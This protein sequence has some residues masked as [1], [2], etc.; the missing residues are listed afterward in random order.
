MTGISGIVSQDYQE[1]LLEIVEGMATIQC[2][3]SGGI[4]VE[5]VGDGVCFGGMPIPN[6]DKTM[7]VASD[8]NIHNH[9]ELKVAL[10]NRGHLFTTNMSAEVILHTYEEY[11]EDCV[12]KL[13][14]MFAFAIWD[15]KH[16]KVFVARDRL[17]IK[18]LYY[19]IGDGKLVF[20][21]EIKSILACPDVKAMV[22][23]GAIYEYLAIGY[24]IAPRTAFDG[25]MKLPPGCILSHK[26]GGTSINEYWDARFEE[27]ISGYASE[28]EY[29]VR[30]RELLKESVSIN[31]TKDV[32]FGVFL[33]GGTDSSSLVAL[34]SEML[35]TPVKTYSVGFDMGE[36]VDELEYARQISRYF[37]TDHH[38][39]VCQFGSVGSVE[40]LE[41]IVTHLEEPIA[42][43][44]I[45]PTYLVSELASRDA[46]II[47]SGEGS[48]E[49]NGG[50]DKYLMNQR[51]NNWLSIYRKIPLSLRGKIDGAP[52]LRRFC[53]TAKLHTFNAWSLSRDTKYYPMSNKFCRW[54][55]EPEFLSQEFLIEAE[56]KETPYTSILN[57]CKYMN[58]SNRL[59][60]IDIKTQ[61]PNALIPKNE[62]T[63]RANSLEVC[64][65]YLDHKLAEFCFSIPASMKLKKGTT[66]YLFRQT[67]GGSL[68]PEMLER[69]QH[70]FNVPL[71]SWMRNELRGFVEDIFNDKRTQ[72]RG[73]FN[74]G[75]INILLDLHF[76][77]KYDL[78]MT[79]L[80][81]ILL[82]LWHRIFID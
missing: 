66:K 20:A 38:E 41:K 29:A 51:Y 11:G 56:N 12:H 54:I 34:I 35:E 5:L 7:W 2:H 33:S 24:I 52:I 25:I 58:S 15:S 78:S 47:L 42:D 21:S 4:E 49:I 3:N 23:L 32:P 50:Y 19:W 62:R 36:P 28:E 37:Q 72:Q 46:K 63:T 81:L 31:L 22:N 18:P 8:G 43:A 55:P 76:Q 16:Q 26:L 77:G 75:A 45:I 40:L 10:V 65:P 82:E 17:G 48:D 69:K 53:M 39:L 68:P 80:S 1:K 57:K 30:L 60:Y 70:G 73:Y 6:E 59:F 9:Q 64:F 67:M 79:I 74:K 71:G 14:G 27:N 61:I 13:R 44:A